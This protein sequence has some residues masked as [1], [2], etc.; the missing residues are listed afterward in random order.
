MKNEDFLPSL[1][2]GRMIKKLATQKGIASKKI[3]TTIHRYQ[4]NADKIFWLN[5]MDTEDVIRISYL[6]LNPQLFF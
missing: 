5:D 6:S 2:I 3:A 1:H 4:N